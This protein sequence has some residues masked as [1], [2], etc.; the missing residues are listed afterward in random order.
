MWKLELVLIC[1]KE[2]KW[3]VQPT[4]KLSFKKGFL[5]K[6]DEC[7]QILENIPSFCG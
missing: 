2:N 3:K 7:A 6:T 4:T 5:A 1:L